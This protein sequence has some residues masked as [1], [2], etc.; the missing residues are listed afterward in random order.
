MSTIK[1]KFNKDAIP[2]N[3]ENVNNGLPGSTVNKMKRGS[4]QKSLSIRRRDGMHRYQSRQH[5]EHSKQP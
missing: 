2:R 5:M 3:Y 1:V 4:D